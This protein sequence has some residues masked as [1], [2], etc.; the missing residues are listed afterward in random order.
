VLQEYFNTFPIKKYL[1]MFNSFLPGAS[2]IE[3]SDSVPGE[4]GAYR[5]SSEKPVFPDTFLEI[6]GC[7]SS[8]AIAC[9]LA[10]R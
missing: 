9:R 4:S 3:Q 2:Y 7:S 1:P 8:G 5:F 10:W 6:L